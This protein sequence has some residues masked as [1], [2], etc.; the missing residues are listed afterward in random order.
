MPWA[1]PWESSPARLSSSVVDGNRLRDSGGWVTPGGVWSELGLRTDKIK[2]LHFRLWGRSRAEMEESVCGGTLSPTGLL[3]LGLLGSV[4][5]L[6][7][8]RL[9]LRELVQPAWRGWFTAGLPLLPVK[10]G[11]QAGREVRRGGTW[12]MYHLPPNHQGDLLSP[13]SSSDSSIQMSLTE[14]TSFLWLL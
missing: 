12:L 14:C 8:E 3:R 1:G 2:N 10:G 4:E 5:G 9:C 7:K 13:C 6:V 11:G